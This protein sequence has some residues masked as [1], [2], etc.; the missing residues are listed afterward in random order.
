MSGPA[1]AKAGPCGGKFS[2]H[3]ETKMTYQFYGWETADIRDERG[4]TPR[5]YYALL[6]SIWCAETCAPRMRK[7]WTR[8]N[9]TLGQCSITAFLMQDIY[10]GRVLGVSLGDGN[11]HCFNAVGDCVFDLTSEQFGHEIDYTG[12]KV[13]KRQDILTDDTRKRYNVLKNELGKKL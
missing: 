2:I 1:H 4:L 8:E 10:G 6:S 5:D 3:G 13:V 7:D 9:K 11:Y 12:Y